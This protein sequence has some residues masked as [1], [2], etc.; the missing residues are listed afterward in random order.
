MII[1]GSA[2]IKVFRNI[3]IFAMILQSPGSSLFPCPPP[4]HL[5]CSPLPTAPV[6][7]SGL[8]PMACEPSALQSPLLSAP[9]RSSPHPSPRRRTRMGGARRLVRRAQAARAARLPHWCD[10]R[11]LRVG[12]AA[13]HDL[14]PLHHRARCVR[15]SAPTRYTRRPWSARTAPSRWRSPRTWLRTCGRASRRRS[16]VPPPETRRRRWF[17]CG[18]AKKVWYYEKWVW[19]HASFTPR[20][21]VNKLPWAA[22]SEAAP[23]SAAFSSQVFSFFS[24]GCS[25]SSKLRFAEGDGLLRSVLSFSLDFWI[26][27]ERK[28]LN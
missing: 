20:R 21:S 13:E 2:D 27:K 19:R 28:K 11:P 22:A 12:R 25:A 7:A 23:T 24:T 15:A 26:K 9:H 18:N 14:H 3:F 6:L 1:M 4:F 10:D 8:Y 5:L 17:H 16:A